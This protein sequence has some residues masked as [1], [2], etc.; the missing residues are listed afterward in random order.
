M[1]ADRGSPPPCRHGPHH[2]KMIDT[3]VP[4]PANR[5]DHPRMRGD[6]NNIIHKRLKSCGS[7]PRT[8]GGHGNKCKGVYGHHA[9]RFQAANLRYQGRGTFLQAGLAHEFVSR[10]ELCPKGRSSSLCPEGKSGCGAMQAPCN[11]IPD[12]IPSETLSYTDSLRNPHPKTYS[13]APCRASIVV[14]T[15][16][17]SAMFSR[18]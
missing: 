11:R 4:A 1:G 5:S 13:V 3:D 2:S 15:G 6:H 10:Y 9:I 12:R 18:R 7:S 8:T 17:R 14:S 16:P